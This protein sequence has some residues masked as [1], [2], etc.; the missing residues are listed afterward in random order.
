ML[1][2]CL[3]LRTAFLAN[4]FLY[5]GGGDLD[6]ADVNGDSTS[7][8]G[9]GEET[10][11]LALRKPPD[12]DPDPDSDDPQRAAAARPPA[13]ALSRLVSSVLLM[14]GVIACI[15]TTLC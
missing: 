5:R 14:L 2:N 1:R 11:A 13:R 3:L 4:I 7:L 15:D 8:A 6:D 9:L 10:S 12:P